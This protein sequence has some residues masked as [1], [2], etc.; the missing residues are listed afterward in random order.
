MSLQIESGSSIKDAMLLIEFNRH[1]SLVVVSKGKVIGVVSDGDI[2]KALLHQKL[3]SSPIDDVMNVNYI[4]L[5][6]GTECKAKEIFDKL[7]YVYIIPVVDDSNNLIKTISR[8][9]EDI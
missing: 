5:E 2:R 3:F 7:E 1:K 8:L 4:R 9:C 6:R